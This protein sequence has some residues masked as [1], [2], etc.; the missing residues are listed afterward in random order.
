MFLKSL[1]RG[2]KECL[3]RHSTSGETNRVVYLLLPTP[4][5]MLTLLLA[6]ILAVVTSTYASCTSLGP[7]ATDTVAGGFKLSIYNPATDTTT[8]LKLLVTHI[9]TGAAYQILS[10]CIILPYDDTLLT[11]M[12]YTDRKRRGFRM[13]GLYDVQRRTCHHITIPI[14]APTYSLCRT[15][16]TAFESALSRHTALAAFLSHICLSFQRGLLGCEYTPG[17][18]CLVF[19]YLTATSSQPKPSG[20]DNILALNGYTDMFSLCESSFTSFLPL[21]DAIVFNAS[22]TA[23][24]NGYNTYDGSSC[25]QVTVLLVPT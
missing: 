14:R 3:L 22:S 7:G 16:R 25:V 6:T 18:L 9:D 1:S 17:R 4:F 11:R 13:A 21:A 19:F 12:G 24:L 8:P 10:V 20:G 15:Q 5:N 23:V 2:I